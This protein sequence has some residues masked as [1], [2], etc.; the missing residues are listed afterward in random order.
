VPAILSLAKCRVKVV[1]PHPAHL[2]A[3][4]ID[5]KILP[6]SIFFTVLPLYFTLEI[7]FGSAIYLST[8]P[9]SL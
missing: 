6:V 3:A 9:L 8:V 1:A 4:L 5:L 7:A 2:A